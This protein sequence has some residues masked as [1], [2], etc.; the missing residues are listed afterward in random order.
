[1]AGEKPHNNAID[2]PRLTYKDN[3]VGIYRHKRV[4]RKHRG[5]KLNCMSSLRHKQAD[6]NGGKYRYLDIAKVFHAV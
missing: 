2:P 1:M 4:Y 6:I 5:P 3:V